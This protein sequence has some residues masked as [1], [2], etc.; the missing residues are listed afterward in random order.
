MPK[1]ILQLPAL[2][3]ERAVRDESRQNF[4][5]LDK[6]LKKILE[7]LLDG[8]FKLV[9]IPIIEQSSGE[10]KKIQ[11]RNFDMRYQRTLDYYLDSK[12]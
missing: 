10:M 3:L 9:L 11:V 8:D 4:R 12:K 1:E 2:Y 5:S 6:F 7:K